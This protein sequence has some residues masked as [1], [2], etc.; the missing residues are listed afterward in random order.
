MLST[1]VRADGFLRTSTS[2][3]LRQMHHPIAAAMWT[4]RAKAI[5]RII[6][7]D[8]AI[9][10]SMLGFGS[11][12]GHRHGR[13]R[14]GGRFEHQQQSGTLLER[15]LGVVP[16]AVVARLVK[17][18]GQNVHQE[19]T[20]ELYTGQAA[21]SPLVRLAVL[22]PERHVGC[23]HGDD[24]GVGDRDAEGIASEVLQHGLLTVAI[25]LTVTIDKA[26]C[27]A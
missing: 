9:F 18:F 24:S 22:V 2:R 6:R 14:L 11:H 4:S 3:H 17:T 15:T 1:C 21:G 20:Q 7:P 23:V 27:V 19:P 8:V 26:F 5:R 10:G 25:R 16:Q 13:A 12:I